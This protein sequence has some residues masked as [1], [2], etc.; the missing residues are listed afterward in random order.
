[1][2]IK[3]KQLIILLIIG[4][5]FPLIINN[6]SN[7][8]DEQKSNTINL[9]SSGGYTESFIHI[10]GTNPKNWS[11]TAGNNSWCYF[12]SGFYFIENVTIDASNSPIG[13]GIFIENSKNQYFIIRNCTVYNS[14]ASYYSAGIRF[15]NT[16]NGTLKN[17]NCYNNSCGIY[18]DTNCNKN[19]ITV[20]NIYQ[21]DNF[22]IYFDTNCSENIISR[23][24][25]SKNDNYAI[26]FNNDNN[27]LLESKNNIITNNT[28]NE[29]GFTGIYLYRYCYNNYI[30]NNTVNNN[31]RNGIKLTLFCDDNNITGNNV[32]NN[33]WHGLSIYRSSNNNITEN[34]INNNG[35]IGIF[36]DT[37]SDENKVRNNTINRN[38][39]GIGL[40]KSDDNNISGNELQDNRW[41]IYETNCYGTII[42]F[43][44]C[45]PNIVEAPIYIDDELTGVDAHNW[46]WA[47]SQTWCT[48]SGTWNQ[49]YIIE[50]RII[51]GFGEYTGIEIL[52]SNVSFI[53]QGCVINNS[54]NGIVLNNVN[55]SQL[56][57]N[58]GSNLDWGIFLE[59]CNNMTI[60]ENTVNNNIYEGIFLYNSSY[61]NITGNTANNNGDGIELDESCN[62]NFIIEN[63][64]TENHYDGIIIQESRNNTILGNNASYNNQ[65]IYLT[66]SC[67]D[68]SISGNTVNY[69]SKH[70]IYLN[71]ICDKNNVTDNTVNHNS[72]YGI[73]LYSYC[74]KNN[75][76]GNTVND[77]GEFGIYLYSAC[78]ENNIT[79]NN[80][81]GN[82]CGIMLYSSNNNNI[83]KNS[84]NDNDA[85]IV[86]IYGI[87]NIIENND[88]FGTILHEPIKIDGSATGVG[89]HNWTW[90]VSQTWC[91]GS[92][93]WNDPYIIE[94]L[95]IDGFGLTDC[96]EIQASN[97]FFIIRNCTTYNSPDYGISLDTVNN[98]LLINNNCTNNGYAGIALEYECTNNSI[99]D[100]FVNDNDYVGIYLYEHCYN[101][102][103]SE[104]NANNNDIGISLHW[105]TNNSIITGNIA[106][107][108][109]EYGIELYDFC[110]YNTI[111]NNTIK[112]NR[113]RGI[114]L[115][116]TCKNNIISNNIII[117]NT[118]YGLYLY[119]D[120]DYNTILENT[121][122][123]NQ[124]GITLDEACDYN[125][126]VGNNVEENLQDGILLVGGGEELC[127]YNIITDNI[128]YS[129]IRGI[130]L[131][132][133]S[134]NN[135]LYKN[136]FLING[137]HAIDNGT[138]NK[139]N[140]TL[141]GNY[142]DNHISPDNNNDGIVD[143]PYTYINGSAD[144]IDYLPIAENGPPLI[145]INSPN[146]GDGFGI[147]APFF[148]V[149]V[150][151]TLLD[152]MWYTIDGGSVNYT[153]TENGAINQSAW[154][155]ISDGSVTLMFYANDILGNI[156][157]AG[158]NIIKDTI[159]PVIIIN[160]PTEN[161]VVGTKAPLLI[162]NI[163]EENL[164]VSWYSFD[165][166]TTKFV[167]T[168]NTLL[169]Q[170]AWTELAEGEVTITFY[171]NDIAGN[172]ASES[173][174]VIKSVSNGGLDPAVIVIIVV[175]SI[176]GGVAVIS[177]VYIFLKKRG[178]T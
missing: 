168:N 91:T 54:K 90:A 128:I 93:T 85:C 48:G 112:N 70:G 151:D 160:S 61:N 88:C 57:D 146:A 132:P 102:T 36:L 131:D 2:K 129:N 150:A 127:D 83:S 118:I 103:I 100:N 64:V 124:A 89:A 137:I 84:L 65:G 163:T 171:A 94:D 8:R 172:E 16:C 116:Y 97:V 81:D 45:T 77:N 42:E 79:H 60:V 50:N 43:N 32:N 99:S 26:Y 86:E 5:I 29:N 157:S 117:N 113:E 78:D 96:I 87:G 130:S 11:W 82:L 71:Y 28:I 111:S 136:V 165:G 177:V 47:E 120:C 148:D 98:S 109:Q 145:T 175:I 173:V 143:N 30:F 139:W 49:P 138:E 104:N 101:N 158:V 39:L 31:N 75:V 19:N 25:V 149:L 92:G 72:Q 110:G 33:D 44:D 66:T 63:N 106:N 107:N 12:N 95:T 52:N 176:I 105:Y 6:N 153:F 27:P 178:S 14:G 55:H 166:G 154:D 46:T 167:I 40:D 170:T 38:D 34:T 152:V 80:I 162:I 147:T 67:Y 73:Y 53:I 1:M 174:N 140:S 20:N 122:K 4:L 121:L 142:W 35:D 144:S 62:N 134:D 58:N 123:N 155:V 15:E 126:I 76:S 24:N 18:F 51:S 17:N 125:N 133:H 135:T 21:N 13:N 114:D 161:E 169:N 119:T 156:G 74:D 22:G 68:N 59:D 41:C 69:N 141:I 56:I 115:E 23:N 10:D 164:N 159:A 37:F 9:K 3:R 7:L 108:N